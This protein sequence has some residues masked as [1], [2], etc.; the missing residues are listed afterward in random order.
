MK[1]N[2]QRSEKRISVDLPAQIMVGTQLVLNGI[3][4]DLSLRSAFIVMKSSVYMKLND[5]VGFSIMRSPG[6]SS[7]LIQG[8]ARVSRIVVGDGLAIYFTSMDD[9]STGRLKKLLNG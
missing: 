2:D 8:W 6:S 7:V 3:L 4:K 1:Q 9:A 5:E